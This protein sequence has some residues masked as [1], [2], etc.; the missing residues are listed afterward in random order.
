[1]RARI[2]GTRILFCGAARC[3]AVGRAS[4]DGR[5]ALAQW[6]TVQSGITHADTLI[7]RD[8]YYMSMGSVEMWPFVGRQAI[9]KTFRPQAD[10]DSEAPFRTLRRNG[11]ATSGRRMTWRRGPGFDGA[12]TLFCSLNVDAA[13]LARRGYVDAAQRIA[14]AALELEGSPLFEE[15]LR[16]ISKRQLHEQEAGWRALLTGIPVSGPERNAAVESSDPS[17]RRVTHGFQL[18]AAE[19]SRSD[20]ERA[21]P[22]NTDWYPG[23]VPSE[24]DLLARDP[25]TGRIR[26]WEAKHVESDWASNLEKT[27]HPVEPSLV[28][29]VKSSARRRDHH[30]EGFQDDPTDVFALVYEIAAATHAVRAGVPELELIE[31]VIAGIVVDM[32][33]ETVTLEPMRVTADE[34]SVSSVGDRDRNV[35]VPRWLVDGAGR[36]SIGAC[37]YLVNERLDESRMV[38]EAMPGIALGRWLVAPEGTV[39]REGS[40]AE[41]ADKSV[42]G[43]HAR[44]SAMFERPKDN[45][46]VVREEA[47]GTLKDLSRRPAIIAPVEIGE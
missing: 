34:A 45:V 23:W 39:G 37:V 4:R 24:A 16:A 17:G 2:F 28:S 8:C 12:S 22:I 32:D 15:F 7:R 35:R 26:Y 14:G 6:A 29:Y 10:V 18:A 42:V 40:N 31:D 5:V 11:W 9:V 27:W 25:T 21:R 41:H 13:R 33:V 43:L 38:L 1:M 3:A 46:Y 19:T 47:A 44:R 36:S 20:Q 30:F